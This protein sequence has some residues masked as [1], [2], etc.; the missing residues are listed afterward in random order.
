MY[1]DWAARCNRPVRHGAISLH[2][3]ILYSLGCSLGGIQPLYI[4]LMQHLICMPDLAHT[5]ELISRQY[6]SWNISIW[7]R[8]KILSLFRDCLERLWMFMRVGAG[9]KETDR[10]CLLMVDLSWWQYRT[11]FWDCGSLSHMKMF[12]VFSTPTWEGV[13]AFLGKDKASNVAVLWE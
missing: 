3:K 5:P 12:Y 7:C 10:C 9:D 2:F 4:P 11:I 1:T 13:S 6:F 8:G